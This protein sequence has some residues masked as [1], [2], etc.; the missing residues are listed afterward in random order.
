MKG[1]VA[2]ELRN[3][4][5]KVGVAH[6]THALIAGLLC[7]PG[8]WCNLKKKKKAGTFDIFIL[9]LFF[10]VSVFFIISETFIQVYNEI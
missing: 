1:G 3:L 4:F 10:K 7:A 9:F 6:S 5:S 8:R 2:A